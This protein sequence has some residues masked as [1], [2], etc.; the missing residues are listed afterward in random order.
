MKIPIPEFPVG[1]YAYLAVKSIGVKN[2]P[3]EACNGVRAVILDDGC[4]YPCPACK[5]TISGQQE[6]TGSLCWVPS[7]TPM[8]VSTVIIQI[9]RQ[10]SDISYVFE[11][12]PNVITI[13][14][15][16]YCPILRD[17]YSEENL[18]FTKEFAANEC[19]RRNTLLT[20]SDRKKRWTHVNQWNG[21]PSC[22]T[23]K[24]DSTPRKL[25]GEAVDAGAG[26][27]LPEV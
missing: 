11:E 12:Q 20:K 2:K 23:E 25:V 4:R 13:G 22:A 27:S 16:L 15:Y 6:V 24:I 17:S 14:N 26:G 5:T 19:L 3:C 7:T 18:F 10:S 8:V 9:S 21:F 1:S